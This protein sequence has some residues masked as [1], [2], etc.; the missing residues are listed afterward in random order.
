MLHQDVKQLQILELFSTLGVGCLPLDGHDDELICGTSTEVPFFVC[1][2]CV[3]LDTK[4][5]L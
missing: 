4:L 5:N 3:V 2:A 1:K